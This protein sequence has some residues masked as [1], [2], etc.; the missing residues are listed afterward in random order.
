MLVKYVINT[1]VFKHSTPSL[2]FTTNNLIW[3]MSIEQCDFFLLH[4]VCSSSPVSAIMRLNKQRP[5]FFSKRNFIAY[6][7]TQYVWGKTF[8][9]TVSTWCPSKFC[10]VTKKKHIKYSK[11]RKNSWKFVY[12]L[13]KQCWFLFNLRDLFWQKKVVISRQIEIGNLL[14][15]PLRNSKLCIEAKKSNTFCNNQSLKI[16]TEK[17]VV[18][19]FDGD[20]YFFC[21]RTNLKNEDL[22]GDESS[23][24]HQFLSRCQLKNEEANARDF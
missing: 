8:V 13:P 2:S 19:R 4:I 21:P 18:M 23:V 7:K 9:R 16:T 1:L 20:A 10:T 6:L 11:R 22:W 3:H 14:W 24:K 5:C 17:V 15:R 12:I